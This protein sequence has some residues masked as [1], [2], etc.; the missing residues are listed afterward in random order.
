MQTTVLLSL[1]APYKVAR[2]LYMI[3]QNGVVKTCAM[4][5][6]MTLD[7]FGYNGMC[8]NPT[9]MCEF[10]PTSAFEQEGIDRISSR[11][12]RTNAFNREVKATE[13]HVVFHPFAQ[14]NCFFFSPLNPALLLCRPKRSP[15][16]QPRLYTPPT[17]LLHRRSLYTIIKAF[18]SVPL[19]SKFP[20]SILMTLAAEEKTAA[21]SHAFAD[22]SHP[23]CIS[24][25]LG[26]AKSPSLLQSPKM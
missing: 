7:K 17:D 24:T 18:P 2:Q 11:I 3:P 16:F 26:I 23:A 10:S 15:K 1:T 20:L 5:S 13:H 8:R 6:E 14:C 12:I 4:A 19:G 9:P 21:T 25:N 22:D